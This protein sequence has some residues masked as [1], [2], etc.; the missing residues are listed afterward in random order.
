M[1]NYGYN[2]YMYMCRYFGFQLLQASSGID[3]KSVEVEVFLCNGRSTSLSCSA[4]DSMPQVLEVT[5]HNAVCV[6]DRETDR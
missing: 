5:S 2:E 4:Y 1:C 6:P 3:D